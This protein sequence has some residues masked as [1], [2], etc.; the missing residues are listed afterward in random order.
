MIFSIIIIIATIAVAFYVISYF[1]NMQKCVNAGQLYQNLDNQ[2]DT[3]WK[4]G[5]TKQQLV[6][7]VPSGIE[8]VCFGNLTV[9]TVGIYSQIYDSLKEQPY[10]YR[11]TANVFLYPPEKACQSKMAYYKL[12]N[13]RVDKF[14]C[15][16]VKK[17][18]VNITV[19]KGVYDALPKIS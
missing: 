11:S 15:R 19:E 2:I 18:K 6:L 3:A 17:N 9:G 8:K 13:S 10:L 12:V 1:L 4:G 16:D 14:F 5:T 7:D